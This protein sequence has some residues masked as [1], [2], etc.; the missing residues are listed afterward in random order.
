[1][2]IFLASLMLTVFWSAYN[3]YLPDAESGQKGKVVVIAVDRIGI[4]D[5]A[6]RAVPNVRNL[7]AQGGIGL[8]N[9]R[10]SSFRWENP[11]SGYLS[12]N[13]GRRASY[14][15]DAADAG[16]FGRTAREKGLEIAVID[17]TGAATPSREALLL[18]ADENGKVPY[19][20]T[21]I[22]DDALLAEFQRLYEAADIIIINYGAGPVA[23]AESD[24]FLGRLTTLINIKNTMLMMITPNP[25]AE[26]VRGNFS[27][28]PV[29][30]TGPGLDKGILTSNTTKRPGLI[31]N[32]D[33][34]PTVMSHFGITEPPGYIGEAVGVKKADNPPDHVLK[35]FDRYKNLKISR[36]IIH[37][38]Y[39]TVT[40]LA[41][42]VIYLPIIGRRSAAGHAAARFLALCVLTLPLM[43]Y[44]LSPWLDFS[45]TYFMS[46]II[47]FSVLLISYAG[48]WLDNL[49]PSLGIISL[50]TSLTL[51]TGIFFGDNIHLNSPLGYADVFVGGRYYGMGNDTMGIM[52]GA[53]VL[54]TFALFQGLRFPRAAA[55]AAGFIYM[56][57]PVIGLSPPFGANVGGTIAAMVVAILT[58][59]VLAVGKPVSWRQILFIVAL[60]F[61][62]EVGIAYLDAVLN[63]QRTHAGN[64]VADLMNGN[65]PAKFL[66]VLWSK[67]S[68]F[69]IMMI[70]PPWNMILFGEYYL[71]FKMYRQGA[72]GRL[73]ESHSYL[74]LGFTV[75]FFG[76]V[77]AFL[78]N[79]TGIIATAMMYTYLLIPLGLMAGVN[80]RKGGR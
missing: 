61:A 37:G 72:F 30:I 21:G 71:L 48:R 70:V 33:F 58:V 39:V 15:E 62:V 32:V 80:I 60:V 24:V 35:D 74:A 46:F 57:L 54:G 45:R 65:F 12:L 77:V 75:M 10:G 51:L 67:L 34:V 47:I 27:L 22:N 2:K 11:E 64:V 6:N 18:A 50:L 76:G 1:M 69:L 16:G 41:L 73:Y 36:Y 26:M 25:P 44:L 56:L 40:V 23:L 3:S 5:I 19:V 53:S 43:N 4:K 8:M 13:M 42:F 31:A 55:V 20:A 14:P 7:M 29:V 63:T 78:F 28:T 59:A 49:L 17:K 79:D 68:L 9:V 52:L 66:Q 38:F